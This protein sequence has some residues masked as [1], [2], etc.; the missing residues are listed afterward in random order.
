MKVLK[1]L[2][3]SK[4]NKLDAEVIFIT[5]IKYDGLKDEKLFLLNEILKEFSTKRRL[6]II[7]LDEIYDGINKDFYAHNH[8]TPQGS[9][10]ISKIIFENLNKIIFP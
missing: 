4:I 1:P 5:Q 7:K 8:T 2:L 9:E 6:K 3:Y 10:R